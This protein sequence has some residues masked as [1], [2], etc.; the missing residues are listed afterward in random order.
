MS[1]GYMLEEFG[2]A[3]IP[4][5]CGREDPGPDGQRFP[6]EWR[7]NADEGWGM[8]MPPR[9][10]TDLP[11]DAVDLLMR[12]ID[13]SP[14]APTIVALGPGPI[15]RTWSRPTRRSGTGSRRSTRWAA[16]STSRAT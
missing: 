16:R 9:P 5:G 2:A 8:E 4:I 7:L 13:E 1:C 10:Q 11:V 12:T 15:S 3:T 6:E 14:S